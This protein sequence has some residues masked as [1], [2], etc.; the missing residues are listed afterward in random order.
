MKQISEYIL[1]ELLNNTIEFNGNKFVLNKNVEYSAKQNGK[2]YNDTIVASHFDSLKDID[3]KFL[4]NQGCRWIVALPPHTCSGGDVKYWQVYMFVK[5]K[6]VADMFN[7]DGIRALY[8]LR[9]QEIVNKD[10]I[11]WKATDY[12][13]T[14]MD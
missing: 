3:C 9:K 11:K 7:C 6:K 8:D 10:K 5:S 13:A 1:E 4:L 2:G 12:V 14:R